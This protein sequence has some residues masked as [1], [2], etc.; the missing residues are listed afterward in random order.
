MKTNENLL[1]NKISIHY[2]TKNKCYITNYFR[3][4]RIKSLYKEN[5]TYLDEPYIVIAEWS[6][7]I[8][9]VRFESKKR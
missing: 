2:I 6:R 4:I 3:Y 8:N 9:G 5:V 7:A 1:Y